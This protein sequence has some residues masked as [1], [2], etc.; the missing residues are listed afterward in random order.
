MLFG[1]ESALD[2]LEKLNIDIKEI[3]Y[4]SVQR[5]SSTIALEKTNLE[6]YLLFNEENKGKQ[7]EFNFLQ[8]L[9][10]LSNLFQR[11]IPRDIYGNKGKK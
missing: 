9:Q 5:V 1:D 4:E 11:N 7:S 3:S 8:A 10:Q 6:L 2:E